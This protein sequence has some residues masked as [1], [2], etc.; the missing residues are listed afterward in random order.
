MKEELEITVELDCSMDEMKSILSN[1]NFKLVEEFSIDDTYL[2]NKDVE[3]NKDYL[4]ILKK[5]VLVRTFDVVGGDK[6]SQLVYKYKEFNDKKE[7]IRQGKI[8]CGIDSPVDCIKLFDTINFKQLINIKDKSYVYC[9]DED[10]FVIQDVND[11]HIYI[12]IEDN[13]ENI[14]K[15]YSGLDEMKEVINK[16]NIPIKNN[17]YFVKKAEIEL[18]ERYGK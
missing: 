8:K 13:C 16:Y 15:K 10:E 1:N 4:D 3:I 6:Y 17:N 14:D 5:C 11:K 18:I 9:N 2:I 12:E 7:I